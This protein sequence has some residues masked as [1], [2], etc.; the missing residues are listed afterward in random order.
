[1]DVKVTTQQNT[2]VIKYF[3]K[4]GQCKKQTRYYIER[5]KLDTLCDLNERSLVKK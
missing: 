1:M 5:I 2:W 3:L 4:R